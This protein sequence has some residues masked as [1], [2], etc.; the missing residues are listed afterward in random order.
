M[1]SICNPTPN[2]MASALHPVYHYEPIDLRTTS[3]SNQSPMEQLS[4]SLRNMKVSQPRATQLRDT[5]MASPTLPNN[6]QH[7]N[8]LKVKRTKA[9]L[10]GHQLVKSYRRLK[11]K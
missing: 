2:E 3:H 4:G 1:F 7:D 10:P 5:H 9:K 6:N 11:G 8:G